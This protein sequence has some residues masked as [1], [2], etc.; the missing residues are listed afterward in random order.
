MKKNTHFNKLLCV[1]TET[2]GIA[3]GQ[4]NPSYDSISK[5]RYQIVSIG[6]IVVDAV[7]LKSI[8]ELYLEIK[9]DGVS[10]WSKQ[11][12]LIHGL[13][14]EY[15]E[16][17]GIEREDAVAEICNL[18][19]DH[20]GYNIPI[21]VMGNNVM[22]DIQFLK[23]LCRSEG[24]ELK[25]SNRIYDSNSVGFAMFGT[26]DSD[27]LFEIIGGKRNLHNSLDDARLSL[28]VFQTVKQ[29]SDQLLG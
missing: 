8:D 28:K 7:T 12:E 23:A 25:V 19:L 18:I 5:K 21:N 17:H 9:W 11:A 2:S 27:E 3:F 24:I 16:N 6:L 4:D 13:S 14:I 1:D 10:D 20:F 15:L 29:L 26:Y 22:F